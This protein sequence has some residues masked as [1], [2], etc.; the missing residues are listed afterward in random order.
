VA[1]KQVLIEVFSVQAGSWK[2]LS[3][4]GGAQVDFPLA[5]FLQLLGKMRTFFRHCRG[6]P[7]SPIKEFCGRVE[8]LAD[9]QVSKNILTANALCDPGYR[10]LLDLGIPRLISMHP[11]KRKLAS[12][13]C[14]KFLQL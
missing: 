2:R 1:L 10:C 14:R 7:A 5:T 6:V 3:L 8:Q 12:H 11:P 4:R 9:T 13:F